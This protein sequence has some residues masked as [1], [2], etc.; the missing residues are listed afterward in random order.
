MSSPRIET[1]LLRRSEGAGRVC[2]AGCRRS[3][4]EGDSELAGLVL[5]A[6]T[7]RGRPHALLVLAAL[8]YLQVLPC[9]GQTLVARA[10]S[11]R[12]GKGTGEASDPRSEWRKADFVDAAW[13]AGA[14]PFGYG[15]PPYGTTLSDMES[16][17]STLFLRRAFTVTDLD[18]D[19][20]LRASVDYDDGFVIWING[21]R[22]WARNEPDGAPLYNS[23]A[24]AD[25]ESGLFETND[26]ANPAEFVEIGENII[27]VQLFNVGLDSS[28][29]KFDMELSLYKRVADTTFSHDRGF[30]DAAFEVTITTATAGATIRWTTDG[31]R[32]TESHGSTAAVVPIGA[33][34]CLR[35]AA[36]K[37]GHVPANVDTHT[38]VF[39]ADVIQ[40]PHRPAGCPSSWG[41]SYVRTPITG[42]YEMDPSVVSGN[43]QAVKD[44]LLSLPTLSIVTDYASL[45]KSSIGAGG[46]IYYG[47]NSLYWDMESERAAS[48]ELIDPSGLEAGFQAECGIRIAGAASREKKI[49]AKHSFTLKFRAE[50]GDPKLD[51]P[52]F[53]NSP[54]D[55]FDTIRLRA[56]MNDAYVSNTYCHGHTLHLRDQWSR[57]T[58]RDMGWVAADGRYVH[59]YLNGLYW[60]LYNPSE[61]PDASFMAE[62]CGGSKEDYDAVS[63]VRRPS[64]I[65][66][67]NADPR[68][69][70]GNL[71]AWQAMIAVRD[72]DLGVQANYEQMAQHLD[73]TQHID[74]N[75]VEMFV[76]NTDW[77]GEPGK[78]RNWRAARKSRNRVA[79]DPQYQF[80]VWDTETGLALSR[81]GV[82]IDQD[83]TDRE[84]I[85]ALHQAMQ[86]N[87]DYKIAFAD[88]LY[89][90]LFNGGALTPAACIARLAVRTNEIDRAVWAESA[91]WGDHY[92]DDDPAKTH[93]E[94]LNEVDFFVNTYFSGR[95]AVVL[96]Q[97][98]NRGLYPTSVEP[99]GFHQHG[100]AIAAGFAL[101]LS[102]PNSTGTI[103]YTLDGSDPRLAGGSRSGAATPYGSSIS[104]GRTTHV[105]ARVYKANNTWSAVHAATFNYT[106]HYAN[107]RITEILYNPLGGSDFEFVEIKNT[108]SAARGLSE[109]TV[110]GIRY[111]F[112]PGTQ[113]EG[114]QMAVLA[115]NEAVF[116]NRYPGVRASVAVFGVYGGRLDNGGE[117]LALLDA[118][119][120]TV[121]GVRYNDKEPWPKAADGD[122]FSLVP[123]DTSGDAD[124]PA[125]WRASNLIGGSPG[126]D[127]GAPYRVVINEALTHTDLPQVDAIELCNAGTAP[128]DIGGWYLSDTIAD[129]R[130]FRIPDGTTLAAGGYVVFD[131][132][133]FN[134][135]T[136]EPACFALS[137]HGDQIHLTQWDAAS[138]LLYLA[139]VDFGGAENGVAFGRHVTSDGAA[140]ADFVAQSVSN[141]LGGANAEPKVG[142]VVINEI[143]YHPTNALFEFIELHNSSGGPVPLYETSAPANTWQITGVGDYAFPTGI[144]LAAGEYVLLAATNEAAFRAEYPGVSGGVRVFGPYAGRLSDGG[145]SVRLLRPDEPDPEGVP[146]ILVDRVVYNDDSPWPE[147]ADGGGFSLE[148]QAADAYG[149]DSAN[150]TASTA[151]GGT[152]GLANCGS[153][154]PKTAGW[155]YQDGGADLGTAWRSPTYDDGTWEDG[156]AP[157]GYPATDTE[158]DTEI[159][160][161]ENPADKHITTYFRKAFTLDVE[162]GRVSGLA[163][164]I[165]YDDGF[166]AYLGG[167]E[168]A[169]GG[170]PGGSVGF[171]TPAATS[172]GSQG[173]YE[174][175]DLAPHIGKLVKGLN[176]LAVE[177]HQIS[178]DSSDLFLDVELV[179]EKTV[180]PRVE[181]PVIEPPDGTV[182]T[183]SV[184]VTLSTGTAGATLFYTLNGDEPTTG[185]T[186]YTGLPFTLSDTATVRARAYKAGHVESGIAGAY[187][188]KYKPTAATPTISPNGGDFYGS[189]Q[190]TLATTTGGATIFYT[191]NGTDPTTGSIRYTGAPFTLTASR[192]VTARAYKQDYNRSA[193]ASA[194]FTDRTPSVS[195]AV[196]ASQGAE[197]ASPASVQVTLSGSSPQTITVDYA[198][199]GGSASGGGADYSLSGGTLTFAPGQ[200]SR[201]I[202]I[203]IVDDD[204]Q[205]GDET[206]VVALSSPS[207]ADLGGDAVHTY[208]IVDNDTLFEAY[209]DL[210]WESGQ[211]NTR[212][213][214]Y[215]RGDSGLLVDYNT[216]EASAVTLA[217]AG[218]NPYTSTNGNA[219]A[220]TDAYAVFN[221]KVDCDGVIGYSTTNLTLT[222]IGL[223]P[224]LVYE[225]VVFGNRG[226]DAYVGRLTTVA[227]SGAAG[228][229]NASTAGVTIQGAND[230]ISVVDNGWNTVNGYVV[231]YQDID[232]GSDG[233]IVLELRDND[234][235]FYA[236][237]LMVKACRGGG[238]VRNTKVAAGTAWRYCRGTAE[239]S[240]PAGAWRAVGFDDSAWATGAAPFGYTK[241]EDLAEE[242]PFGT[243]LDDMQNTYSSL[244][245]RKTFTLDA[246]SL[247]SE[248]TV[249][250]RY[251]DGFVMWLNGEEI[252]R[253]NADGTP[254]TFL[255][256][257]TFA[258]SSVEPPVE[259]TTACDGALLPALGPTNVLAVQMLNGTL[260]SSDLVF[261]AELAALEGSALDSGTDSDQDGMP[262]DWE[263]TYFSGQGE[264]TEGDDD[265][266]GV[267]NMAEYIAGSD[268]TN[269]ASFFKLDLQTSGGN[270]HVS[271]SALEAAGSAYPGYDRHYA[272]ENRPGLSSD[273]VWAVIAG[274]SPILGDGTTVTYTNTAPDAA[275]CYRAKVWLERP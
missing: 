261:D 245:L 29:A 167:E 21:E 247:V 50:Y 166:V 242:G 49:T 113:L 141:T 54:A 92:E 6:R 33:T 2:A 196:P 218:G 128:V 227:L 126:Y 272:L 262:D 270:L 51:Y 176:V 98:R 145:E 80:F 226:Q 115:R 238:Q 234:S 132:T 172:N 25:H 212:I 198:P 248:L 60:G 267:S 200:T 195:F 58:Q 79:S 231:R 233:G 224:S 20:R 146:Y 240:A 81:A 101:T 63:N 193:P 4:R 253:L 214:T 187:L 16:R 84:G 48:V 192:T 97:F 95:P 265:G 185:S 53:A 221:G 30:Y 85:F 258:S 90:H 140:G 135:D 122:G 94:W 222:L 159:S 107:I 165:R 252:A 73:V 89:K 116:T 232:P 111:T 131:E 162:P 199:T 46:G 239:P 37:G 43:E 179:C 189:V 152:P 3:L 208:T 23:V 36:F 65:P 22:V 243:T 123:A 119:G 67:D 62:H 104:L 133:Q 35:A 273:G 183:N 78:Y 215:S 127:D 205:E 220:G 71:A 156:N 237:A 109:M 64:H 255:P 28:D 263:Q 38:Y 52:L 155:R 75:I 151:P 182:F 7:G 202:V 201:T 10:A 5:P 139:S 175:I 61:R 266:D 26:I 170:M 157:L 70:D 114:G 83:L 121:T 180:L 158:I 178:A 117:R 229:V 59:L 230:E 207:N 118:E 14:A 153:L 129:Y 216:G 219:D 108:G 112:A 88:R 55:R 69:G 168:V 103:Y 256:H 68:L 249:W 254:G 271:F 66:Y 149:N 274:Y 96:Q 134:T 268:P 246:P 32:P 174:H 260:D 76:G 144:V 74:Y 86:A 24:A 210:R 42:D 34:T 18:S 142:P 204:A 177:I 235:K 44:A 264:S 15:D 8:L 100:G 191:T 106:A 13:P 269:P 147:N 87:K 236:N 12:Y 194:G 250:A 150:W 228:F 82:E 130:K 47:T 27:A 102:N 56:G 171:G 105:K 40:Q 137:S 251:D 17:Y 77:N 213:T 169:R 39:A 31:S 223:D 186:E 209:N 1:E 184:G 203:A 163:L 124:D 161:G 188:E 217:V 160:Y 259:W 173:A 136:N 138:N 45:W 190:V 41:H 125:N 72:T 110:D 91:R 93:G 197:S 57:D 244:F 206:V 164:R 143:M 99:P 120:R 211:I 11:W 241:S 9:A 154:V 19:S 275:T 225:C 181:T 148:R 257:D